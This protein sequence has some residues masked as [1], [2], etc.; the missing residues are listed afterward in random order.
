MT[1]M[2]KFMLLTKNFNQFQLPTGANQMRI[3]RI[4][5]PTHTNVVSLDVRRKY[6]VNSFFYP[7][8]LPILK[9]IPSLFDLEPIISCGIE[10]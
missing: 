5:S 1:F 3:L 8:S 7:R 6:P 2:G 9:V 10:Q 4:F